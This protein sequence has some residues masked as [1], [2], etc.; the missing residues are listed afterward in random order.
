MLFI[1]HFKFQLNNTM[2]FDL[3]MVFIRAATLIEIWWNDDSTVEQQRRPGLQILFYLEENVSVWY[4][5]QQ[6]TTVLQQL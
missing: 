5:P 4:R 6:T 2:N 3:I 1:S